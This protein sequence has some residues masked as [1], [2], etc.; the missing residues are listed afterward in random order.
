MRDLG[1][2]SP[3]VERT[4][5]EVCGFA[6]RKYAD[7]SEQEIC[8]LLIESR[9]K[10]EQAGASGKLAQMWNPERFFGDG[11]WKGDNLWNWKDGCRPSPLRYVKTMTLEEARQR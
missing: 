11:L 2:S 6:I 9:T 7:K 1:I 10:Y 8:A 4:L 3:F 5:T